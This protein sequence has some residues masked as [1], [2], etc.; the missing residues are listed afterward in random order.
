MLHIFISAAGDDIRPGATGKA[1]PRLPRHHPRTRTA[2]NSGPDAGGRL[3]VIGPAGCRYLDDERQADYVVNGWN[4]TGDT[5][6][7]D[8]D[9]YFY[10]QAR[11]DN[12]I[13]SSGYNIGAPEVE[14]AIDQHPDVV[15]SAV[16]GRPDPERG[17]SSAP[18]SCCARASTATP[19][20]RKEI[21]D[22]VKQT[23]APVQ[24]PAR[25]ALRRRRCP[26]TP[27]ASCSTSGCA[28]SWP[29]TTAA[30]EHQSA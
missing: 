26:A 7:R 4:V 25:G 28:S 6:I 27:A 1:G 24:V 19:R 14:A 17:A 12:M 18:S 5:F 30:P 11:T 2:R 10:Y 16:V 3:A 29:R 9:G 8:E 13:V 23:M 21:Q 15:E 22:F 20:R